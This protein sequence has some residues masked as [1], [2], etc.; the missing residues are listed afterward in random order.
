MLHFS[1]HIV[2]SLLGV[3]RLGGEE[4][5]THLDTN[6]T[7]IMIHIPSLAVVFR[8]HVRLQGSAGSNLSD[9]K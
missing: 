1:T 3:E 6:M 8:V 7:C 9:D 2:W 4:S 5:G